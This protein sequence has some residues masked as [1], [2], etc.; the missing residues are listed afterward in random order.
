MTQE[1]TATTRKRRGKCAAIKLD[2]VRALA[3]QGL[4]IAAMAEHFDVS[5][6]GID[7]ILRDLGLKLTPGR[8]RKARQPK[9]AAPVVTPGPTPIDGRTGSLAATGGRYADLCAWAQ[10]WGVTETK[11]RQEWHKLRLPIVRGASA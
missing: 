11:A 1:P 10:R 4:T 3:A 9:A 6:N 8:P 2:D 7:R 5:T